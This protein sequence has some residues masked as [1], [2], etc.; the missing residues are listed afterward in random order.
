MN[1]HTSIRPREFYPNILLISGSRRNTGK[2]ILACNIIQKWKEQEYIIAIKISAHNHDSATP[3][4]LL[5]TEEGFTI[6]EEKTKTHKDS[7]RFLEAGAAKVFYIEASDDKFLD[8]FRFVLNLQG[9]G[10]LIICES[11]GLVKFIQPGVML[12]IQHKD[13]LI[14]TEK[15]YLRRL[16]DHIVHSDSPELTDPAMILTVK[17]HSWR[18]VMNDH[19]AEHLKASDPPEDSNS[20]NSP[21]EKKRSRIRH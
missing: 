21:D 11:G 2:T 5:H 6:W 15:E 14:D 13:E 8:A 3:L 12:F 19:V 18:L 16:S 20:G 1:Y 7:G 4:N 9:K 10:S 17:D